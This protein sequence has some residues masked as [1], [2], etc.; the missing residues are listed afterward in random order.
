MK[1]MNFEST[2]WRRDALDD[3][4]VDEDTLARRKRRRN[5]IIAVIVV[6]VLAIVAVMVM[7]GGGE[8]AVAPKAGEGQQLPAVTVIVPGRQDVATLIS[9]TAARSSACWSSPA[10]GSAPARRSP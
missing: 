1:A 9:A 5:I 2:K 7:G 6:A 10:S 4:V 3:V 8:K